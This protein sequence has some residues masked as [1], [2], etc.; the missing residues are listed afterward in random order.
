MD[1]KDQ[2]E[3][4]IKETAKNL[5][6]KEGKFNATTQEIADAAEV[7]RTLINYYFRSRNNLFKVVFED[8]KLMEVEKTNSIMLAED[9]FKTKISNYI[10]HSFQMNIDYPYLETYLVSQINQGIHFRREYV[11]EHAKA[12]FKNV[13]DAM[14]QGL[15]DRME[16]IQFLL[17]MISLVNFP[18]AMRPLIQLNLKISDTEY[19]RILKDRKEIIIRTLFKK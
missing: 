7:N 14:E 19:K 16:P 5:F 15:I 12:F 4:I 6:F 11:D 10:D 3:Y 2:T 13:E 18:M 8:A 9:D 17:N 1:K